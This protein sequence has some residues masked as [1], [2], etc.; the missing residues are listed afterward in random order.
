M[1]TNLSH[2]YC[3]FDQSESILNS[4]IEIVTSFVPFVYYCIGIVYNCVIIQHVSKN[5][6]EEHGEGLK[7]IYQ[8][9]KSQAVL[10]SFTI[11]QKIEFST[12]IYNWV[13]QKLCWLNPLHWDIAE[14]DNYKYYSPKNSPWNLLYHLFATNK[15]MK[16]NQLSFKMS[17]SKYICSSS[18]RLNLIFYNLFYKHIL[19]PLIEY[20]SYN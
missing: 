9:F 17:N 7:Q 3:Y 20:V 10:Y 18:E 14:N 4:K 16:I 8:V 19:Y 12:T 15:F 2:S 1:A 11:Y 13:S 5:W 6:I